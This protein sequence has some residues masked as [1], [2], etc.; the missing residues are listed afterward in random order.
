MTRKIGS[1]NRFDTLSSVMDC[2]LRGEN[3]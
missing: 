2:V 1:I 3:L